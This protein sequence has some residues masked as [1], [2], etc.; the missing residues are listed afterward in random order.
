VALY[1]RGMTWWSDF[2]INGQRYRT[3]L[4]TTD[5][6]EAGASEKELIGQA[7]AGKLAP[8][9]QQYAKLAFDEAADRYTA[10]RLAH[11]APRSIVT[12]RERLKPLRAFFS[13]LTLTRISADGVRDYVAHRKQHGA[14]NRTLNMELGILR[15]ILKR[16][17]R[18]HLLCEDVKPLPERHS[19]GRRTPTEREGEI[20]QHRCQQTGM[21]DCSSCCY[22]GTEHNYEGLRNSWFA[23]ARHRLYRKDPY[24]PAQ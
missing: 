1:K 13:E 23:V 5:W 8:N 12:E 20:A 24:D 4:D 10:D 16:A 19:V 22:F 11:L 3:S 6:R 7:S 17:K 21:A 15:R 14:A 9:G 2:S 18:W